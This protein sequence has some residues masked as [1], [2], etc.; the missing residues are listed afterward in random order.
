[1][2]IKAVFFDFFN[3][4]VDYDPPRE[5]LQVAACREFGIE[6]EPQTMRRALSAGDQFY[7]QE[8]A[9]LPESRRSAA[10]KMALYAQYEARILEGLG[11]EVSE[12]EA[13]K[14]MA[15]FGALMRQ[16]GAKFV[17]FADVEPA[18]A[19]LKDRGL[20]L[21]LITNVDRD[22]SP[23]CDELGLSSYLDFLVTSMAVGAVKPAPAIFKAALERAGVDASEA[24][25]VGD[26]YY[27]DVLGARNAGIRA[28]LVDRDNLH[29]EIND[30]PRITSLGEVVEHL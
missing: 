16:L 5:Q 13:L 9:R 6:I 17:L 26:Q 10:E 24:M 7:Y 12:E 3:T 25:H 30:C 18:L 20:R 11:V 19:Q 2:T 28:L 27:S 29:Q 15:K 14:I 1:M 8:I 23:T 4:L 22:L 21:G